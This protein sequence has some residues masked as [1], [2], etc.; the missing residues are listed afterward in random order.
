MMNINE[1]LTEVN[2]ALSA[3]KSAG[4]TFTREPSRSRDIP[5]TVEKY[6]VP[7]RLSPENWDHVT[8]YVSTD[9]EKY[10]L[11]AVHRRLIAQGV[12]FDSGG[13][14]GERDWEID[15]SLHLADDT[16][17]SIAAVDIVDGIIDNLCEPTRQ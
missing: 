3:L 14:A 13:C 7:D 11:N 5:G 9:N 4:L 12:A 17:Q 10:L 16:S 8:F 6:A 2:R 15:W 1:A